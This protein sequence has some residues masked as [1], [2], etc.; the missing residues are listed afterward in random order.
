M[1]NFEYEKAF[2]SED[3]REDFDREGA[4]NVERLLRCYE[5]ALRDKPHFVHP[6]APIIFKKTVEDCEQIAKEFSGRIKAK[7]DYTHFSATI[8]LWCCYVEFERREFMNT[9]HE[10]SHFA[11]SI[12]FTPLTSGELYIEIV[13][14]YFVSAWGTATNSDA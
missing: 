6:L 1:E 3:E 10:I 4:E 12:R 7:I 5:A 14:P 2:A 13:M 8:E 9:L 11:E